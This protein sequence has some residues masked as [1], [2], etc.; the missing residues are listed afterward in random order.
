MTR[1]LEGRR[2]EMN[3]G[4]IRKW[5]NLN[6]WLVNPENGDWVKLGNGVILG[7]GVTSAGLNQIFISNLPP[8]FEAWKWVTRDR[9]SPN[10]DGGNPI[11]Y[12]KGAIIKEPA[13]TVSDQQC[14]VGLH[15]LRSGYRP[16]WAGLCGADHELICL[17]VE[18]HREDVCF[19]GLPTMDNKL[20][21]KRLKVLD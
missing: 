7:N 9:M 8:I 13:A 3:V 14:D 16:E 5:A 2:K 15:V 19:G 12:S 10:F 6:G 18:I 17:R 1:T 21:V 11:E 20:R 4:E